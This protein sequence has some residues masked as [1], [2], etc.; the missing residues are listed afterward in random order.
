MK[1]KNRPI[2]E[3]NR[4]TKRGLTLIELVVVLAVAGIV[5]AIAVAVSFGSLAG[6][7]ARACQSSRDS[8]YTY[9]VMH[10]RMTGNV[11]YTLANA[12]DE[13]LGGKNGADKIPGCPDA[14]T[15]EA[16]YYT[17]DG[18]KILCKYH[19]DGKDT[20]WLDSYAELKEQLF[21]LQD[22][23]SVVIRGMEFTRKN[24]KIYDS[25]GTEYRRDNTELMRILWTAYGGNWPK[26]TQDGQPYSLIPYTTPKGEAATFVYATIRDTTQTNSFW[27]GWAASYVYDPYKKQWY[28]AANKTN[29][30]IAGWTSMTK[31]AIQQQLEDA[32]KWV[33]VDLD[34]VPPEDL[35]S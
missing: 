2:H 29:N 7:H 34:F 18:D 17:A 1:S 10:Q 13:C 14:K 24:N 3:Q 28:Q 8:I 4:R 25:A 12:I 19:P 33:P 5:G 30:G 22:N 16:G 32:E 31:D 6:V 20:T 15:G 35:V 23:E 21:H 26:M 27:G 11:D 9:W